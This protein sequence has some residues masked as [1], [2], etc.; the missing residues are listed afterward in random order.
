MQA[1]EIR[2]LFLAYFGENN[3][4]I[5]PGASLIPLND[6]S[7]LFVNA[8]MVQFKDY[9]L[10]A[11]APYQCAVSAQ[12]CLRVGGKHNDL[13]NVGH[14]TRHHTLFEMLG[15]FSFGDYFKEKAIKLAWKFITEKLNISI[16]K[17]WVT[18]HHD[19]QESYAIWRDIIGIDESRIIKC[20]DEDNF[21]SMGDTGP[22]GPCTE[23]FYDHGPSIAG[24]LPGTAD[25]D[26]DRYV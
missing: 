20:G 17:L 15:N 23:I 24:G 12:P 19:D 18:V 6:P 21:W 5:V 10:G 3:H 8:G 14:T 7:L 16:D 22:C 4:A 26:G 9:F 2:K 13:K 1:N 25:A 11:P